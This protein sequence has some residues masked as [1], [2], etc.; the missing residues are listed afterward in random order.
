MD[1]FEVALPF[2]IIGGIIALVV[3]GILW[4]NYLERKRREALAAT[5]QLMGFT[6]S[7]KVPG[8]KIT[9][10]RSFELFNRG[11]SP[12][13]QNMLVGKI[14]DAEL[15]LFDYRYETGSGKNRTTHKQ[16]VI[17]IPDGGAG[18]PD[19]QLTP[20]D[21]FHRVAQMF[22]YQDID[23]EE[24]PTFS[25]RYLLRGPDEEA[26]R[27]AFRTE[28]LEYFAENWGWSVE[29][30]RG[31]LLVYRAANLCDPDKCPEFV[32]EAARIREVLRGRSEDKQA[33]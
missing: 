14:G 20:E 7:A 27:R 9:E 30:Q 32:A 19:F 18:L 8:E 1:W 23:F 11:H 6:W 12:A 13:G 26:I 15:I 24:N 22:G 2:A 31:Q 28:V 21:F 4:S 5:A 16:T 33:T 25:K 29:V 3:V 10:L 17:M